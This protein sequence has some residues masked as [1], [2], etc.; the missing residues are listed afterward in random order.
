M[1]LFYLHPDPY[2]AAQMQGD[3]HVVKMILETAQM[4]S[5]A[6]RIL[7]GE[8]RIVTNIKPRVKKLPNGETTIVMQARKQKVWSLQRDSDGLIET[9]KDEMLYKATH[10][11][12][13]SAVW[14]RE[15]AINYIWAYR[16][17]LGLCSE[18][19]MRYGKK[20]LTD[21]K[22]TQYLVTVPKKIAHKPF[23][24]PP[25][26]MPDEYK[27]TDCAMTNYRYYYGDAKKKM[28]K[29]TRRAPPVW[30]GEFLDV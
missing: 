10:V 30:I 24:Q 15:S 27:I 11:N 12:H 29:W 17:F 5:T 14:I 9:Q 22:L 4:L 19:T 20:H 25:C 21:T 1:N 26:C 13:P 18:Y 23:V 7:D 16:H 28:H 6:H 8:M 3:K 2:I